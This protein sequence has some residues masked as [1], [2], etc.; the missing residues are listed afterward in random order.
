MSQPLKW[1]EFRS[2]HKGTPSKELS[3]LWNEYKEGI[4]IFPTQSK[5]AEAEVSQDEVVTE[6]SG[7]EI[8]E[9]QKPELTGKA[10][11][12][13]LCKEYERALKNL[14]RWGDRFTEEQHAEAQARLAT[15]AK[16]TSPKG[17]KCTPT[18]SWKLWLGPTS[19]C[20]LINTTRGVA[21]TVKRS[22]WSKHY[23]NTIY[24]DR[25][26][27][28][29]GKLI[30]S[31]IQRYASTDSYLPRSPVVGV[32]CKLPRSVKEIQLRGGQAQDL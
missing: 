3:S 21:F 11:I 17:Y 15:I 12:L 5:D 1:N 24:V 23:Q 25:E 18:D 10:K 19:E 30:W 8:E 13:E 9:E 31:E 32:E 22:W 27:L 2:A 6:N 14:E 26:L 20:L 7:R 28:N 4:Y 29:D 16:T